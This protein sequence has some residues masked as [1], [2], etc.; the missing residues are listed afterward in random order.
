MLSENISWKYLHFFYSI[1]GMFLKIIIIIIELQDSPSC[2][3][4]SSVWVLKDMADHTQLGTHD[5]LDEKKK[6]WRSPT[7]YSSMVAVGSRVKELK[8]QLVEMEAASRESAKEL[9]E[10]NSKAEKLLKKTTKLEAEL[11]KMKRVNQEKTT[12][13]EMVREDMKLCQEH[14]TS[15]DNDWAVR[16]EEIMMTGPELGRGGW[17]TVSVATFRGTQVAAKSIHNFIL[18]PHNIQLFRREM[19]MAAR[20]RHPNLVQFIG[21]TIE[22]SLVILTE[23]MPTSLRKQLEI[24]TYLQPNHI[25]SI[26][27]DVARAL[28]Y[29]HLMQPDPLIHRDISSANVLLEQVSLV[30]YRAKVADY[31]SVNLVRELHTQNPGSP[32]YAAPETNNPALQ[33]PKMDIYSFGALLLEMLTGQLP[34]RTDRPALLRKVYHEQ[35]LTIIR[36]CLNDNHNSRPDASSIIILLRDQHIYSVV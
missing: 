6:K 4:K 27:L 9:A 14:T 24:D 5:R 36:R 19:N 12:E 32:V 17:A 1:L 3:R 26:G 28:N 33:S 8:L 35:L 31:G 25:K 23:L 22:G 21:A 15:H 11:A 10:S 18:S 2:S 16:R 29:M 13:V 30:H 7:M 34:T 20:L